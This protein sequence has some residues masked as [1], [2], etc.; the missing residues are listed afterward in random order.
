MSNILFGWP[1]ISDTATLS[2]GSWLAGLPL[3]NLATA[4]LGT[5]ARS[6]TDA[7]A[8]TIINV[9]HGSAKAVSIVAM[10]RHNM[11][12]AATWRIRGG[13]DVTFAT[14]TY[15]SGTI[16]VW[17]VQWP[18][19]VLPAGHPNAATRLLTD[20]QISALDPPRDAVHVLATEVTAR[21]W[22]IEFFDT[23]NSDTYVQA[24]RLIMAPRFQPTYN[25]D[26]GAEFGF[27]GGT[28]VGYALSRTRFYD[29]RPK[30]RTLA[31]SL[32]MLSDN[33]A[34]AVVRDMVED[35]GQD[36]QVYVV[37]NPADTES[38]QRRSF[39]ANLRELSAVQYAAAGYAS[40]PL[41]LDEV[42]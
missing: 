30:G 1:I 29:V 7:N 6:T 23:T 41:V 14:N 3:T 32:S 19:N 36:G 13:S 2:G 38:L 31:L 8:D 18:T 40:M 42:V 12:S 33:E 35:L 21:Y 34:V 39:L 28:T 24:G 15:D 5:V 4:A 37:S 26:V 22:R 9:D 10:V 25:M 27:V 20:A 17:P 16:S 11:R